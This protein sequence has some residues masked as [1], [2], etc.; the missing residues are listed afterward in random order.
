MLG[1]VLFL[2][3][4]QTVASI[5][6]AANVYALSP[7]NA[8]PAP[9]IDGTLDT[10]WNTQNKSTMPIT[11]GTES[12][13]L[14]VYTT[15]FNEYIYFGLLLMVSTHHKN[16]SIAIACSNAPP[17]SSS[18]ND[19]VYS[20]GVA[21]IVRIDGK[22]WDWKIYSNPRHF[23]NWS[24]GSSISNEHFKVGF[25]AL[26]HSF[27][28][29]RFGRVLP[30]PADGGGDVNWDRKGSYVIKIFYGTLFGSLAESNTPLL[31]NW[32]S[33]TQQI[34][35]TI[36]AAPNDPTSQEI[37]ALELNTLAGKVSLFIASGFALA[38]VGFFIMQTKSRIRRI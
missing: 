14:Q 13:L 35:L 23:S 37:K 6:P 9:I 7:K 19:S 3:T 5:R 33:S 2:I 30:R 25:G 24:S 18:V 10:A 4:M 32:T 34:T 12:Q 11:I 27:Y 8:D 20:Y 15:V 31:G 22:Q 1:F 36:P 28:E 29:L 16:E 26:N 21:K 38:M 17:G